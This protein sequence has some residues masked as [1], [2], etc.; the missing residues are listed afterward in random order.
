MFI[1]EKESAMAEHVRRSLML[2][3]AA[4]L[5]M[6]CAQALP[7]EGFSL[8]IGPPVAAGDFRAKAAV[9]A[10]RSKGCA[11]PSGL[12]LSGTAEGL[13]HGERRSVALKHILAMPAP[14]V[15]T[16][17]QEWRPEGAWVVSLTGRCGQATAA[18]LVPIGPKGFL[19]E[20]SKFFPRPAA[21]EEIDE[22]LQA[23]PENPGLPGKGRDGLPTADNP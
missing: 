13:V 3:L 9:F 10:V 15:F 11:E 19:R 12:E 2:A 1:S 8:A 20:S 16:V 14:G 18:A 22:A 5:S 4:C 23:L 7:A 17:S 6:T 21:K